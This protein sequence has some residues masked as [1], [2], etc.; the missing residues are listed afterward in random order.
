MKE[1]NVLRF[2]GVTG[3]PGAGKG[4]FI[5]FLR[6]ILQE[7]GV[8]SCYYSLSD[9]LRAE[10]RR[11][12]LVV[13][14]PVLRRIANDLRQA[15]GSGVLSLLVLRKM[16]AE[17]AALPDAP[18]LVVIIDSIRNPEEVTNLRAALGDAFVLVAVEAPLEVLVERIASR[19]RFDE[20]AE[21]V[22]HKEATRQ[23]ILKEMGQGEP[24]HGHNIGS[25]IEMADW[26]ADNSDSL[27]ALA[28]ETQ[29]FVH[30][31]IPLHQ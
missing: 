30:K 20:P 29:R 12:D 14:R 22:G 25:C 6:S 11:R 27:E 15:Q 21:F 16:R 3:L 19:A 26:R 5:D 28:A 8:T 9:E 2:V 31:M 18:P 4:A 7:Q 23:M 10:A 13:E 1:D 17:V 24:E